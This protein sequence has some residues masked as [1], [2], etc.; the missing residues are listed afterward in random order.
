MRKNPNN[1]MEKEEKEHMNKIYKE[2]FGQT[3]KRFTS[4][5]HDIA[6]NDSIL[7]VK[8]NIKKLFRRYDMNFGEDTYDEINKQTKRML[9]LAIKRAKGNK[10]RTVYSK[11][12]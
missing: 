9:L 1:K 7:V 11:D 12:I 2:M 6:L 8:S 10:R 5:R 4:E 3:E